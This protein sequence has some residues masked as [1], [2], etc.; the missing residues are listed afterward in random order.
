MLLI[1]V[2]GVLRGLLV[3]PNY[4]GKKGKVNMFFEMQGLKKICIFSFP[5]TNR[6]NQVKVND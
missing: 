2:F 6:D 4:G 5:R 1:L 3:N